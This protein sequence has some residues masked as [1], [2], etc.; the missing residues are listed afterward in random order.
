[1]EGEAEVSVEAKIVAR[2]KARFSE[3]RDQGRCVFGHEVRVLGWGH[4]CD[5]KPHVMRPD[6][7]VSWDDGPLVAI[8]CKGRFDERTDMGRAL[9][10]A[11]DYSRAQVA[12]NDASRVPPEWIGKPI[13]ASALA[14]DLPGSPQK[15][16]GATSEAHRLLGPFNCGFLKRAPFGLIFTIGEQRYWSEDFKW[17]AD[18]F[19]R[20]V[21]VGSLR[22]DAP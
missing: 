8:E 18:A 12:A 7:V 15:I 21:R 17:R 9:K 3:L 19:A 1:M 4:I 14:F 10:Q 11:H 20:G 13:W 6:F 16:H 2:L 22:K 5:G